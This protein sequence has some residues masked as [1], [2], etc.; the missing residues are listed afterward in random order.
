MHPRNKNLKDL[1]NLNQLE[2]LI[3]KPTCYKSNTPA[4]IDLIITNHETSFMKSD[5]CEAGLSDHHKMVY[6]FLRKTFAKGT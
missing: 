6:S 2:H 5:T 1:C 3:L 4:T